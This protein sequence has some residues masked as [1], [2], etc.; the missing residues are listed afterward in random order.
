M[1]SI[2]LFLFLTVFLCGVFC[3]VSQCLPNFFWWAF[4]MPMECSQFEFFPMNRT[5][6]QNTSKRKKFNTQRKGV[7]HKN[8][9]CEFW[10]WVGSSQ[11]LFKEA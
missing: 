10:K 9:N 1:I 2:Y 11:T 8:T 4:S 3:N 5:R 7:S 6:A